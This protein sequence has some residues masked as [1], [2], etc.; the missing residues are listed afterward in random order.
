VATQV[1]PTEQASAQRWSTLPALTSVNPVRRVKPGAAVLLTAPDGN[2]GEEV[3]L[4]YQRF[5][6]GKTIA[7]PVQDSWQWQMSADIPVE[8]QTHETFWRRL[9][10]W[11][12]DGVPQ[13]LEVAVD[14][15]RVERGDD[16]R[17]TATLRDER[18]IG[19][20]DAAVH[21]TITGPDG[22]TRDVPLSLVV[23]RDGEYTSRFTATADGFYEIAVDGGKAVG[24]AKAFVR[25]AP[26]DREFFDPSMRA[27]FLRRVAEDTGG[28][29]YTASSVSTL[30]EDITYLG[31]GITVLQEKDLWDMPV[32]LV[33]LVGLVGAE[34]LLRR[35]WGLA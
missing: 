30:P 6:A 10:R 16:V 9:L 24:T 19:V 29:F 12:D 25:A 11:V 33:I 28:P 2:R 18:F 5:G 26:D 35:N 20:N 1:G 32:I 21:A 3:V 22:Q 8:D 17:V 4:A 14:H 15:E 7:F 34:W 31:R 27:T 23:D 13:R